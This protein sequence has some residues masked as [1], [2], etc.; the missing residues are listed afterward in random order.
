MMHAGYS[1]LIEDYRLAVIPNWHSSF[2]KSGKSQIFEDAQGNIREQYLPQYNPGDSLGAH[3]EFALK[4]DGVNLLILS[5]LFKVVPQDQITA[6]VRTKP[7]G[8]YAR[9]IWY[10]YEMLTGQ[11]LPIDD[12]ST[13]NYAD[14]LEPDLYYTAHDH[15]TGKRQRIRD[16]LLGNA[17]FCPI[18]RRTKELKE[19]EK[20]DLARRCRQIIEQYPPELLHRAMNYLYTKETKSSFEIEH[21]SP[22][23]DRTT[24]FVAQLKEA[25]QKDYLDKQTLI[26]LQN[27]IVDERFGDKGYRTIQNYVGESGLHERIHYVPPKPEDLP[28]L[29]EGLIQCHSWMGI[30]RVPPVVHAAVI[31]YGFVFLHP[32]EDGN[33]RIH[34]F[35]IHNILSGRDFVPAGIMFPISATMLKQREQYDASLEAYSIPLLNLVDYGLDQVGQ[36]TVRNQTADCYRFIDFTPLAESLCRFIRE[37]IEVELVNELRYLDHYDHAKRAIQEIV[38]MPDRLIDLFIHCCAQNNGTISNRKRGDY[39]SML[40]N[41]EIARMEEA[42]RRAY[43]AEPN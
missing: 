37:T 11:R 30:G 33:G 21:V 24:R 26:A 10:L 15:I 13:G 31:S 42:F 38:D 17:R 40:N 22:T 19:F 7:T 41:D 27:Q 28:D 3:L 2:I 14:L 32:F 6:Y 1:K 4:Y 23:S 39:F 25:Q 20:S 8:M 9:R 35:L 16:N 12:L 5:R 29:M 43:H 34:R 36:M 18:V